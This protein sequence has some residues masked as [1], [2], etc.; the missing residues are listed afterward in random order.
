[1]MREPLQRNCC[2]WSIFFLLFPLFLSG[3]TI[4]TLT[5]TQSSCETLGKKNLASNLQFWDFCA[6][7]GTQFSNCERGPF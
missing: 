7:L 1:M 4:A 5:S 3:S 6:H 2:M